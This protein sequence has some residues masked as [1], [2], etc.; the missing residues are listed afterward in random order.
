MQL[1]SMKVKGTISRLGEAGWEKADPASD[2][3]RATPV[4]AG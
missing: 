1:S 4:A 2:D 3:A